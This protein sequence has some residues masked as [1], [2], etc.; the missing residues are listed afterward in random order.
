[1]KMDNFNAVWDRVTAAGTPDDFDPAEALRRF[2]EQKSAS[3]EFYSALAARCRPASELLR[4]FACCERRHLRALQAEYFILTGD[5]LA[6]DTA[7]PHICGV[8]SA[9]RQA[10]LDEKAAHREFL[11]AAEKTDSENLSALLRSIAAD[12]AE[13]ARKLRELIKRVF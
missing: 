9:L 11:R 4:R 10:Y 13:H 12:D 2:I 5:S 7:K 8:L 6:C 1:M 3:A